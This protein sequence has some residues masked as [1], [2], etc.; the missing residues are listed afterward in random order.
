M[1]VHHHNCTHYVVVVQ[2]STA[3]IDVISNVINATQNCHNMNRTLLMYSTSM[4]YCAN[5]SSQ[6]HFLHC[7]MTPSDGYRAPQD[8]NIVGAVMIMDVHCN[9]ER[10]EVEYYLMC[11]RKWNCSPIN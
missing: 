10:R 7:A 1:D 5:S 8:V 4:L 2:A 11:S 9:A 3:V 6:F